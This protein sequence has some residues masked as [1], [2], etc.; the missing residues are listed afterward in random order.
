MRSSV[1]PAKRLFPASASSA[2]ERSRRVVWPMAETMMTTPGVIPPGVRLRV[3]I[4]GAPR[5][6]LSE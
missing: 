3:L 5:H 1:P 4:C 2:M 6:E